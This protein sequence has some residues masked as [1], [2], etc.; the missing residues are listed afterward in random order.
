MEVVEGQSLELW[1]PVSF[2]RFV[3]TTS[4]VQKNG[5]YQMTDFS[6][7]SDKDERPIAESL[8]YDICTN[9]TDYL[10]LMLYHSEPQE[11]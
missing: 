4:A 3:S 2:A 7:L 6:Q 8:N 5:K 10:V 1:M 11:I 9:A